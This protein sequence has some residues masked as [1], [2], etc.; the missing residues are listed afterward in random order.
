M[1]LI[2]VVKVSTTDYC[3]N[4]N[5]DEISLLIHDIQ[6]D[7]SN[8]TRTNKKRQRIEKKQMNNLFQMN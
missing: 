4:T 1:A 3:P 8:I 5:R 2:D 7:T 6:E